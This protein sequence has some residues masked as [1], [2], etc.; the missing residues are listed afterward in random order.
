MQVLIE[1]ASWL[2]LVRILSSFGSVALAGYTIAM[3]V[4]IFALLPSWGLAGSAATLVGQNLGAKSPERAR[5]AVWTVARYNV[6]FLAAISAVFI[7]TPRIIVR[8]FTSDEAAIAFGRTASASWPSGSSPLRSARSHSSEVFNGAGDTVTPM[9]INLG[10]FWAIE[11]PVAYILARTFGLGPR[12]VFAAITLAYSL[13][14]L[15]S[16]LL[17]RAVAGSSSGCRI[18]ESSARPCPRIPARGSLPRG[19]P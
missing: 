11:I 1:T 9:L 4:A 16:G 8:A 14:A 3:R 10:V 18:A 13:Q 2:G 6:F 19:D 7:L 17:F 15:I 5:K 12:G